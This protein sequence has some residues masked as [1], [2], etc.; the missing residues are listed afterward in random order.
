[1][2]KKI[3]LIL[4]AVFAVVVISLVALHAGEPELY[5][6]VNSS[7]TYAQQDP[8]TVK[9]VSGS[10]AE[11]VIPLMSELM[12]STGE[13]VLNIRVKDYESAEKEFEAYQEASREFE[14]LVVKL[15]LTDT[16][17]GEFRKHNQETRS[18]LE[19][20]VNSTQ[21]F[22]N[23]GELE[24]KYRDENNPER[25]Y[26]VTYEG[27]DL[28]QQIQEDAR[29]YTSRRE[30]VTTIASRYGVDSTA[31]SQSMDDLREIVDS[32]S[33][34]QSSRASVPHPEMMITI[35]PETGTYGETLTISGRGSSRLFI[36]SRQVASSENGTYLYEIEKGRSGKHLAYL[37]AGDELSE[38]VTF[39]VFASATNI[40]LN[41]DGTG[42]L[43]AGNIPV[44]GAPVTIYADRI[45]TA[46]AETDS[47]GRYNV[48]FSLS[49]GEHELKAVFESS[50]FPLEASESAV[51]RV[52]VQEPGN[53]LPLI[54]G[55]ILIILI[56]AGI[57][58]RR[59]RGS[60][61]APEEAEIPEEVIVEAPILPED[62]RRHALNIMD[63]E[64]PEGLFHDLL[65][66]LGEIHQIPGYEYKTPREFA[67]SC[68]EFTVYLAVKDFVDLYETIH[69]AG[70]NAG[71]DE[72]QALL[73]YY[74]AALKEEED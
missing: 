74:L 65:L 7:V 72:R 58:L 34:I 5:S 33:K 1:M 31:Y 51:I 21:R 12:G 38:L 62:P 26:S 20:L 43:F 66:W 3:P 54:A 19:N 6:T 61:T 70:Q 67:E 15:D 40:S 45:P 41:E 4:M 57:Y 2:N 36:D 73:E 49:P 42:T 37:A 35:E 16:D 29:T 53:S 24:I 59:T 55:A 11:A 69:Y 47:G 17:I 13:I 32:T 60:E 22:D 23:L 48:S 18:S 9:T 28:S 50:D 27:E 8:G 44:R 63:S 52:S 71:P 46:T 56:G 64:G 68:R 10:N 25:V 14:N 30:P 39:E